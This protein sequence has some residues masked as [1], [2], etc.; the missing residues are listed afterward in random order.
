MN[1]IVN[2]VITM[3]KKYILIFGIAILLVLIVI[4]YI[5]TYKN[6]EMT[7]ELNIYVNDNIVGKA[8]MIYDN[9][10]YEKNVVNNYTTETDWA[11][12][13]LYNMAKDKIK[14]KEN[15]LINK[16]D[17]TKISFDKM[18]REALENNNRRIEYTIY[19]NNGTK[20]K[21]EIIDI[22]KNEFEVDIN[23]LEEN[24]VY[25]MQFHI[26][27]IYGNSGFVFKFYVK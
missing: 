9:W 21:Y 12:A 16:G 20:E 8:Y 24:N 6:V 18:P 3:K 15:I 23:D 17:K 1:D 11:E 25:Y 19:D 22:D 5:L 10:K 7:K 4:I 2:K 13:A 27:Q 26:K 14:S